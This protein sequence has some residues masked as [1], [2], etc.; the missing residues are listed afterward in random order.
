MQIERRQVDRAR[1]D[2]VLQFKEGSV[3]KALRILLLRTGNGRGAMKYYPHHISDFNNATRHLTRLE[4]GIYRDLID[5]YYETEQQL[6]DD[7]PALCR[8]ILANECS[9]DVERVLNEFFTKTPNGWYHTRCEETIDAYKANSSQKAVAGRASAEKKRLKKMQ[10]VNDVST[11]VQR[12]L[13]S[14][15]TDGNGA[16]TNHKPITNNH[17]PIIKTKEQTLARPDSVPEPLWNDYLK[18]RKS[19]K[20]PMT[21]TALR[22]LESEAEKAG[23]TLADAIETC[24]A[25][26][27]VG[28]NAGW[29]RPETRGSP[30]PKETEKQRVLRELDAWKKPLD[31]FNG[32]TIDV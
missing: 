14:V 27:W 17:K 10:A 12:S 19:K 30:S 20:A 25:R 28:Y 31:E 22:L 24:V 23:V 8:R 11:G 1:R 3:R 13:N 9:T 7:L 15:A 5:L 32:E 16:S 2:F 6:T 4:R 21:E 18:V 29:V 26:N